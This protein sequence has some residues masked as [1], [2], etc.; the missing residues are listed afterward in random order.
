MKKIAILILLTF[1]LVNTQLENDNIDTT[2]LQDEIDMDEI[3]PK[4]Y[5]ETFEEKY[6]NRKLQNSQPQPIRITFDFKELDNPSYGSGMTPKFKEYIQ[7]IMY[8]SQAYL[9]KFIKVNPRQKPNKFVF[10]GDKCYDVQ[11]DQS[12]KT[13]G[14][15]NS[16]LHILVNFQNNPNSTTIASAGWCS[17]DPQ[18]NI[19]RVQFNIG[20][21]NP[22]ESQTQTFQNNFSIALHEI[23]HILG[24]SQGSAY[25]WINPETNKPYKLDYKHQVIQLERRWDEDNVPKITTK[26]IVKAARNHFNCPSIDGMYFENQGKANSKGSHWER[27]LLSNEFMTATIVHNVFTISQFTAALLQDT[28]FYAEINSNFL[29]PIYWGKNQGCDFFNKT[30]K[31]GKSFPEFPDEN[32]SCDYYSQSIGSLENYDYYSQC[33]R[34][35]PY[36]NSYCESDTFK[37]SEYY[38]QN[39]GSG[40]RCFRSNANIKGEEVLDMKG[41]CFKAQC[42]DDLSYIKVNVWGDEYVTCN[43]PNQ[44]INLGE[45]TSTTQGTM[46]CPHDFDLFC[47]FPKS[48]PNN[49]SNNGVCNN[50]YCVCIKGYAGVDCSKMCG[51][52]QVWDGTRCVY[53]CPS[54]QFKN[55]DNTCKPTCPYK[56]FGDKISGSCI[57]CSVNCSACYGPLANQCISCN[58]GYLLSGNQCVES[59]CHS[60]CLTCSGPNSNQCTSCPS[61][62][63]LDSRKTCQPCQQPCENCYGS[64]TQCTTC[65]QGYEMDKF[66]GKCV[67]IYTCDSSCL[68]C[69][70]YRDPTKCTSCRDGQFLNQNGRCQ[71]CHESCA[72]CSE[73][74]YNCK[75]CSDGWQYNQQY[76]RCTMDCHQSCD[77]CTVRQ[78]PKACKSCAF[79]YIMQNNLCVPCDKSC[80]GCKD[81]QKKCIQCNIGYM[82]DSNNQYCVPK[83]RT[84][85]FED[86]SGNCQQCQSPCAT[87]KGNKKYCSSC[88][89][90]YTYDSY[91][92]SCQVTRNICHESCA[93]CNRYDDP[94]SCTSC[95]N[96]MYLQLGRCQYCSEKCQTCDRD[97]E[98]CTSCKKNEFLQN[99]QCLKCHSSCLTCQGI[100]TNCTSCEFNFSKDPKTGLCVNSIPA[101]KSD[102]YLDRDYKCQKCHS[103]CSSCFYYPN[104]CSSCIS[105]YKFNSQSFQCEYDYPT[106]KDGQF[107]DSNNQCQPCDSS[108]ATCDERS[109]RCT[110]CKPNFILSRY[111]CQSASC[112]DGSFINQQGRCQRCSE[113]CTK[114][115]NYQD[116]CTECASGYTLDR[117]TQRCIKSQNFSQCHP[118]CKSCSQINSDTACVSC[119]D[120]YYLNNRGQCLQCN[121]SCQTCETYSDNCTS[122]QQGFRNNFQGQCIPN[123][124]KGQYL[125]LQDKQ[126]KSCT[127]P[128]ES[129]EYYPEKCLSCI[130]GYIYDKQKYSC[131]I[132]CKAGQYIDFDQKCQSCKSPCA[133]C[134]YYDNRCLSCVSGYT[135]NNFY[136]E[137]TSNFNPN[138]N[139]RGCHQSCNTCTKAMDPRSCDS[140]RE[141]YKLQNGSCLKKRRKQ[142]IPNN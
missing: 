57:L 125:D 128:C 24:F 64:A 131:S 123:C 74:S 73:T 111:T 58:N 10:G 100:S 85:E 40:S 43:Y 16:D 115:V 119:Y 76:Q 32:E 132:T 49:C 101:C 136:C 27:D 107:L 2:C 62:Q 103:P 102:E 71:K 96:G 121:N 50:G 120:G 4:D 83:C 118:S 45:I 28:G 81:N 80:H 31:A 59:S 29:M 108:C 129:C 30:C 52:D 15:E 124:A 130:P 112:Q 19:G 34:I 7:K 77:T 91:Y 21:I 105:G 114:C 116:Y 110:S 9:S 104:R 78:D 134:E 23:L 42:A 18:P 12:I 14:I 106:C 122:C 140:C 41:R 51:D 61:G 139:S 137:K 82:F 141:G 67:S 66:S 37:P 48:C 25:Y 63:Y 79:N 87:C 135:Y 65:G 13:V 35:Y 93:Q 75:K 26:N 138:S 3:V 60:S 22:D 38:R 90:G 8:A 88:I 11:L 55:F 33:K 99:N 17:L 53:N 92:K 72:T 5:L 84:D 46:R 6:G 98:I 97:A 127:S 113:S 95:N 36:S 69:S 54:R 44:V 1:Q 94:N 117:T 126:C 39:T 70:A 20:N 109:T 56:Q 86:R 133:T 68:E 47:N 142:Q 89:A